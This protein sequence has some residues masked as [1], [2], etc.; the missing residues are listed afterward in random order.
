[1]LLLN[2]N[3]LNSIPVGTVPYFSNTA[4]C[5]LKFIRIDPPP[6]KKN[7]SCHLRFFSLAIFLG[8]IF[9]L[10]NIFLNFLM[11]FPGST[12]SVSAS[13]HSTLS[14]GT[15]TDLENFAAS[16]LNIQKRGLFRKKMSLKD[17]LSWQPDSIRY[18]IFLIEPPAISTS[19]RGDSSGRRCLSR[20]SSPG[21]RI[22][23]GIYPPT[24]NNL[25]I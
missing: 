15:L 18:R 16:N 17:I 7:C 13:I 24:V 10:N 3:F 21:N 5:V 6:K 22:Q 12:L 23:S 9:H 1:M 14:A 25:N 20:I 4:F 8:F 2:Y 19:R 11:I